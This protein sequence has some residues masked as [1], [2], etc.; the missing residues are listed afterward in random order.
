MSIAH[1]YIEIY[2]S[3]HVSRETL[4][5]SFACTE[6]YFQS[7]FPSIFTCNETVFRIYYK[8]VIVH[9]FLFFGGV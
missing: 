2:N 5:K 3:F 8:V 1:F 9:R 6:N 4:K 7:T